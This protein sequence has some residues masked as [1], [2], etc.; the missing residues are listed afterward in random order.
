[1]FYYSYSIIFRNAWFL[2]VVYLL[3]ALV[4]YSA[5]AKGVDYIGV[6]AIEFYI[7]Y[8]FVTELVM[9]NR[10]DDDLVAGVQSGN[11]IT[12]L[13]KPIHFIWMQLSKGFFRVLVRM[14]IIII[15]SI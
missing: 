9:M 2:F 15:V 13:N 5:K 1:M 12:L 11:I 7:W 14:T 10:R 8:V 6:I 4:L 3:T